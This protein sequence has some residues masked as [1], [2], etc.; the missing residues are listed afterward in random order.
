MTKPHIP[1]DEIRS[2]VESCR[3]CPLAEGRTQTV[4][5]VGN[6]S[7][8]VLIVGEAPGK[9]ED[10]QGEPFVG[11]AGKYLDELLSIAGLKRSSSPTS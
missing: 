6:P 10:L 3:K 4:F 7:A 11:A 9:N 8:R 1:L 5:G 2:A